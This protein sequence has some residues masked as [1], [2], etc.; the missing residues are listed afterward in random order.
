MS[1]S[2]K[3]PVERQIQTDKQSFPLRGEGNQN[4]PK[5]H[6]IDADTLIDEVI[7]VIFK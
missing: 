1:D 6:N 7:K 2:K 3:S 4:P 5:S